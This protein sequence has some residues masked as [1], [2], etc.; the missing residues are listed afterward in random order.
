MIV[1]MTAWSYVSTD[2]PVAEISSPDDDV[3][4]RTERT[5]G[6]AHTQTLGLHIADV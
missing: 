1:Y 2:E 6:G 3:S 5:Q 4:M